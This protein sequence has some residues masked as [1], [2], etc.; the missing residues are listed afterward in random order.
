M[1]ERFQQRF[2]EEAREYCDNLEQNLLTLENDFSNQQLVGEV[3]RIMHS[4]KGS[5]AMFGFD[6]L[7]SI[8]HDLES[9]YELIRDGELK[10]NSSIVG[11]TLRCVD[12]FRELLVPE[13]SD[14][15]KSRVEQLKGEIAGWLRGENE[16]SADIESRSSENLQAAPV[17]NKNKSYYIYFSPPANILN[18]GTNPLYLVDELNALGDCSVLADV[19]NVPLPDKLVVADCYVNW[20]AILTTDVD[21]EEVEDVFLFVRDN[22]TV[23]IQEIER[24]ELLAD[25]GFVVELLE[26]APE[27]VGGK[28]VNRKPVADMKSGLP[29]AAPAAEESSFSTIRVNSAKIDE[30]M[31]LVSEMITAQSRLATIAEKNQDRDLVSLSEHF[32]KLIRQMRDNAFDM[33][34]IPLYNIVTRFRRLVRDL[35]ADLKKEVVLQTSGLETEVDKNIIEKLVDPMMHIIRNCVDHGIESPEER[36]RAGKPKVGTVSISAGYVGT[37][38]QILIEDDGKGLDTDQ[39]RA[40]AISK[41]LIGADESIGDAALISLIFEPGFTTLSS[42]TD[43]SGRGVG[44]DVARK[45]IK[46]LRGDIEIDTKRGEGTSFAIRIPLTLSIIDGL[47]TKVNDDFY[48][49]PTSGIEKIYP[50]K[51][52]SRLKDEGFRQVLVFDGKEIP[53]LNLRKE[54]DKGAADS[55]YQYLVAVKYDSYVFGL[56]VDDVFREYQAV[57]KPMGRMLK[58]HDIFLGA[59]ILGDG[60]VALVLDTKKIIQKFSA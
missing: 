18:N 19:S 22:S 45:M 48:I 13:I 6:L 56:L 7:S 25:E 49:V 14:E 44:M 3:F 38:V 2:A 58:N 29:K 39:I 15:K 41:G 57:V 37:F 9:L 55:P 46:D 36:I 47:L 54:F 24:P 34:L 1:M 42:A 59:S 21:F 26:S 17:R 16:P 28:L 35:S 27:D 53:F 5:G 12:F 40:K 20:R 4:L 43:V 32:N 10:L 23:L 51:K 11:F 50:V 8:T 31:N 30:Y 52:D 33:S 60:K